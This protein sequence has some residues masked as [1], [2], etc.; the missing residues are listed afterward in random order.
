[1]QELLKNVHIVHHH[2]L[3]H[4]MLTT[5]FPMERDV[6]KLTVVV[7]SK[8]V[9]KVDTMNNHWKAIDHWDNQILK[10][11]LTVALAS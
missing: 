9:I 10:P 5:S 8:T 6:V 7:L 1:M 4:S 2:Q 3:N 11:L